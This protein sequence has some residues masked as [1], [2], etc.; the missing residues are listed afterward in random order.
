MTQLFEYFGQHK[1]SWL[2]ATGSC[3]NTI[4]SGYNS[5][6]ILV[7]FFQTTEYKT[8]CYMH[9][10]FGQQRHMETEPH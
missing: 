4:F 1:C 2:I 3:K 5:E 10:G 8:M 9:L 7:G 6:V